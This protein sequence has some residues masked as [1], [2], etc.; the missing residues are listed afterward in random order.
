MVI[1]SYN[2]IIFCTDKN[3]IH[4]NYKTV[5][6]RYNEAL[7]KEKIFKAE[8]D[9]FY[10]EQRLIESEMED[11]KPDIHQIGQEKQYYERYYLA[12]INFNHQS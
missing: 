4:S 10:R 12:T 1:I 8:L 7:E 11:M 5:K 3:R 9:N 2:Y 6:E